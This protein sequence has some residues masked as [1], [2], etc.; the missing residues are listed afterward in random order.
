[1]IT[2]PTNEVVEPGSGDFATQTAVQCITW[3]L[4]MCFQAQLVTV[5]PDYTTTTTEGKII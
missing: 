3:I 2:G 4:G 5:G 1:M